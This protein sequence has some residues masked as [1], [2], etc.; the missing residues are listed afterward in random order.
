MGIL[1]PWYKAPEVPPEVVYACPYCTAEFSTEAEL[2]AH[3]RAAHI[4]QPPQVIYVCPYCGARFSTMSEL[5]DHIARM[6]PPVAAP[7]AVPP[8]EVAPPEV[9][10]PE[11]APKVA[12]IRVQT[13]TIQPS[14]VD[15][16]DIVTIS[17]V[18]K[19][20]GTATGSKVIT[21]D[22]N[23]K[24]SSQTVTLVAGESK[25]VSFTATPKEAKTYQVS[26]NGL[27][28]SFKAVEVVPISNISYQNPSS[29]EGERIHIVLSASLP[30]LHVYRA[31]FVSPGLKAPKVLTTP[32]GQEVGGLPFFY[33]RG[34]LKGEIWGN[35]CVSPL[36]HPDFP[37]D[38]SVGFP[39]STMTGKFQIEVYSVYGPDYDAIKELVY[40]TELAATL[41]S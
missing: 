40:K 15:V 11:V 30:Y 41:H 31:W 2:L 10:P 17:V 6:H 26:V 25:A 8:P 21:C 38:P 7:P 36:P 23:G 35:D 27:S 1:W 28:G 14:Q 12:D 32:V 9:A 16:G 4:G 33:S 18:A 39:P 19:N 22:V 5:A 29:R 34:T 24:V 20:Y 13:L 3:I 37:G